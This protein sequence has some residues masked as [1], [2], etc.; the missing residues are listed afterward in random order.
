MYITES[1]RSPSQVKTATR[2]LGV[3]LSPFI[4]T[5]SSGTTFAPESDKREAITPKGSVPAALDAIMQGKKS[6]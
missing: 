2:K 4:S 5:A 3:D 1:L 6:A